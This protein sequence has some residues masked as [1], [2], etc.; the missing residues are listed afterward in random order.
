MYNWLCQCVER[1]S[2]SVPVRR[3]RRVRKAARFKGKPHPFPRQRAADHCRGPGTSCHVWTIIG[4]FNVPTSLDGGRL[5]ALRAGRCGC[6]SLSLAGSRQ[7]VKSLRSSVRLRLVIYTARLI[8]SRRVFHSADAPFHTPLPRA[9]RKARL[10]LP[11]S[12]FVPHYGTPVTDSPVVS[13]RDVFMSGHAIRGCGQFLRGR[14]HCPHS[15]RASLQRTESALLRSL[16]RSHRSLPADSSCV[17]DCLQ[18]PLP[19][20]LQTAPSPLRNSPCPGGRTL[21]LQTEWHT[22]STRL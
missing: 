22:A 7:R 20:P 2:V 9:R 18:S 1:L 16:P 3:V 4:N 17:A 11:C 12:P 21:T 14:R 6:D 15:G 5:Y 13:L 8:L 10:F 19:N